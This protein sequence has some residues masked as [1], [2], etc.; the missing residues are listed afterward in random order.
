MFQTTFNFIAGH[1]RTDGKP[2][3]EREGEIQFFGWQF[4]ESVTVTVIIYS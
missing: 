1:V 3:R 2:E 4:S